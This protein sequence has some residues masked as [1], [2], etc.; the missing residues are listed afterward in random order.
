MTIHLSSGSLGSRV[1]P[2]HDDTL[3]DPVLM[4]AFE[5]EVADVTLRPSA[6]SNRPRSPLLLTGI[7]RLERSSA[8][9]YQ[10]RMRARTK[11]ADH[12]RKPAGAPAVL[13]STIS[14]WARTLL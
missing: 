14:R 7:V 10:V 11:D 5:P 3:E 2:K 6:C 1:Q 12:R 4:R 9:K 13:D 8:L